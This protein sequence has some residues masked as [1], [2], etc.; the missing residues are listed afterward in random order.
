MQE[1]KLRTGSV[2]LGDRTLIVAALNVTPDSL[3]DGGRYQEPERAYAR[4]LELIE[5]GADVIELGAESIRPGAKPVSE[6]EELRRLVPVLKL[7]RGALKV[8]VCVETSKPGVAEKALQYGAEIIKDPTALIREPDLAKVV[9]AANAGL[10][11]QHMRGTPETWAKL[12]TLQDPAGTLLTELKSSI[13]RAVRQNIHPGRIVIDPGLGMGKRKEQNTDIIRQLDR[14]TAATTPIQVS[15]TGKA[16]NTLLPLD[17][18]PTMAAAAAVAAILRGAC[19]VRVHD[20]AA[21]RPAIL[22]ADEMLRS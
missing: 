10:V 11:I 5:Q 3:E 20:V 22:M 18:S 13:S 2:M 17:P 14:L 15:P 21:I 4:A 8:P 16:F 19:I 6:A 1:W 9:A 12:A 7:L